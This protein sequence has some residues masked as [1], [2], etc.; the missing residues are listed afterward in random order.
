MAGQLIARVRATKRL[1]PSDEQT[2]PCGVNIVR[3]P[4]HVGVNDNPRQPL[5]H[6]GYTMDF[7][8]A[9]QLGAAMT[10]GRPFRVNTGEGAVLIFEPQ[11]PRLRVSSASEG[12]TFPDQAQAFGNALIEAAN[13]EGPPT[14]TPIE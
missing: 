9:R 11:H 1:R 12:W 6:S 7:A 3:W 13:A 14:A 4:F 2:G 8:R 5:V 10:A